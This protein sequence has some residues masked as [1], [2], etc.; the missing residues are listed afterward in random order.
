MPVS[1]SSVSGISAC[2]FQTCQSLDKLNCPSQAGHLWILTGILM[3][4][5]K[6]SLH[7]AGM[8]I[9]SNPFLEFCSSILAFSSIILLHMFVEAFDKLTHWKFQSIGTPSTLKKVI[10]WAFSKHFFSCYALFTRII[11]I[12]WS[13]PTPQQHMLHT[14]LYNHFDLIYDVT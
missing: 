13:S 9:L 1:P 11:H 8:L 10:A 3:W 6:N 4:N 12:I 5:H 2:H 7:I 14:R